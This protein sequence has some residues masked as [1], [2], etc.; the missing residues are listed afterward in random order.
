MS[1]LD[2]EVSV[3]GVWGGTSERDRNMMLRG[4]EFA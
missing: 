2:V 1:I 4:D 3:C